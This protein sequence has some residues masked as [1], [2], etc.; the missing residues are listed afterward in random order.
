MPSED[1]KILEFSQYHKSD[2]APF[3]FYA[4][5]ESLIETIYGCKN[6]PEILFTKKVAE[7][8]PSS[9][10]VSTISLFKAVESKHDVYRGK[11]CMK[12]FC[13]SLRE[14]RMNLTSFK[15]AK[16][17]TNELQKLQKFVMS[18]NE[19]LKIN[20]LKIKNIGHCHYRGNCRSAAH[21]II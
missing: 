12:K 20:M 9:F 15:K 13:E 14:H 2:K 8:I 10:P 17:L 21:G 1:K 4:D 3:N 19:N 16:L 6:N 7:Y 5:L 18:V 11:D